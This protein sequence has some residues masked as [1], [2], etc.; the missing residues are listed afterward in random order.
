MAASFVEQEYDAAASGAASAA[1][2]ALRSASDAAHTAFGK[3]IAGHAYGSADSAA[4]AAV[5]AAGEYDMSRNAAALADA[6]SHL[7]D[8][9]RKKVRCPRIE[10]LIRK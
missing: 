5:D 8:I 9:V 4:Q 3:D 2:A 7:A 6:L 10:V 1:S